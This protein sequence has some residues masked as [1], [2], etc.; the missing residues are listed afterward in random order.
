MNPLSKRVTLL[1][2]D[3]PFGEGDFYKE[4]LAPLSV[5]LLPDET[6]YGK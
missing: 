6:N 1:S 2:K 4:G 3:S 5:R